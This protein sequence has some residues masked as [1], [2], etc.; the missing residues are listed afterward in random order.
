MQGFYRTIG[1]GVALFYV[2]VALGIF[3]FALV[4][5]RTMTEAKVPFVNSPTERRAVVFPAARAGM[6]SE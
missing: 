2:A 4:I 1:F 6:A 5:R 3:T